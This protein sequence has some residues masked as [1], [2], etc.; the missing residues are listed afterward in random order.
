MQISIDGTII[1]GIFVF[2]L[3]LA[4][5]KKSSA[6]LKYFLFS[7]IWSTSILWMYILPDSIENMLGDNSRVHGYMVPLG[8]G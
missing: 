6:M 3:Y 5:V 1:C 2:Y 7:V 4:A 8:G